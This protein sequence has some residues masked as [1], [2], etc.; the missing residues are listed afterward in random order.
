[1]FYPFITSSKKGS[2]IAKDFKRTSSKTLE[3]IEVELQPGVHLWCQC[4]FSKNQPFC[5]GSH[6]GTKHK[7]VSF[8]VKKNQKLKLCNCK[9]S[10][11][12]PFCD[13]SHLKLKIEQ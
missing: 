5:D 7:P 10:K 1:M 3:P 4:G 2:E 12:S 13:D 6:H 8:E 11:T 9:Q